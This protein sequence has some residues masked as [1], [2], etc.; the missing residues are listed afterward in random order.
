MYLI[1]NRAPK[2]YRD[3]A[4]SFA[5]WNAWFDRLGDSLMDRGNPVSGERASLGNCGSDTELGGYTL[6]AAD[7]LEAAIA[8]ASGCPRLEVGGGVEI[9]RLTILN[10]GKSLAI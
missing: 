8:L 3:S 4:E 7:S 1:A 6:V 9:G 2:G 5:A 10:E